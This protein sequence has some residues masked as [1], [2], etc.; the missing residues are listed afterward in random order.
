MGKEKSH[1]IIIF[2][3]ADSGK[4]TT[5]GHL[6]YKCG[7]MGKRNTKHVRKLLRWERAP[8]SMPESWLNKLKAEP[9]CGITMDTSLL[10]C[11]LPPTHLTDKPLCLPLQDGSKIR[12][13]RAVP[14][15]WLV[16]LSG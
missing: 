4:A 5:T 13:V 6:I 3:H 9:E 8:S 11:I 7:G 14:V 12:N 2:G 15:P 1:I 16:W 10:H